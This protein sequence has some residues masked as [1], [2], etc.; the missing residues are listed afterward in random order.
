MNKKFKEAL[1]EIQ[2]SEITA[3]TIGVEAL[4]GYISSSNSFT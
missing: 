1:A 3:Q 2:S 4:V